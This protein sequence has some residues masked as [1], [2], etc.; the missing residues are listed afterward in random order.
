MIPNEH[1]LFVLL[2]L[3]ALGVMIEQRP[4]IRKARARQIGCLAGLLLLLAGLILPGL[5]DAQHHSAQKAARRLVNALRIAEGGYYKQH[6][7]YAGLDALRA[8]GASPVG[9]GGKQQ[10]YT[11]TSKVDADNFTLYARPSW[12][13]GEAYTMNAQGDVYPQP[14]GPKPPTAQERI[15]TAKAAAAKAPK[16]PEAWL[17]LARVL[18]AAGQQEG[19]EAAARRSMVLGSAAGRELLR[20]LLLDQAD[21]LLRAKRARPALKPTREAL[22]MAPRDAETNAILG[23]VYYQMGQRTQAE[24]AYRR[25]LA[26]QDLT[27]RAWL[28]L[29]RVQEARGDKEG[30][31]HSYMRVLGFEDANMPSEWTDEA[32]AGRARLD[33]SKP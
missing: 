21:A 2:L 6:G 22:A 10:G 23:D 3:P 25:A 29:G 28:G 31:R 17:A 13:G 18:Q 4:L 19:A 5:Q 32:R 24:K 9:E 27:A 20:N 11:F 8:A 7:Q 1:L 15:A 14:A 33:T 30:A 12:P 26:L 16:D